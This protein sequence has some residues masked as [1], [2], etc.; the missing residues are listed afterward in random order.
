MDI[1]Y[2]ALLALCAGLTWGLIRFCAALR[3]GARP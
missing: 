1:F 2:I 3:D